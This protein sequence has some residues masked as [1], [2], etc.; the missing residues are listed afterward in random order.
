[1]LNKHERHATCGNIVSL[2]LYWGTLV[3]VSYFIVLAVDIVEYV[4]VFVWQLFFN[5]IC[6]EIVF[7][8][9]LYIL[10]VL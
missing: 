9:Y 2:F 8:N 4:I 7:D 1:M 3:T 5:Y 10:Y 6:K